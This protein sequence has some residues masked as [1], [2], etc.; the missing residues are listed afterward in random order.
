MKYVALLATVVIVW[1][2][3]QR[4]ITAARTSGKGV[5][6]RDQLRNLGSGVHIAVG[7]LAALIIIIYALGIL[8]H[9]LKSIVHN[10]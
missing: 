1:L 3:A 9:A 8:F 4:M 7:L 10:N 5:S 2:L 6:L